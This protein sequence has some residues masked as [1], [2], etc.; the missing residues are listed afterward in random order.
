MTT[1]TANHSV[2]ELKTRTVRGGAITVAAQGAKLILQTTSTV[3]MARLLTPG[4]FGL[5]EM[6]AAF[7]GF[8]YLF[9][10]LGLSAATIQREHITHEE[11]SALFWINI[12]L[13]LLLML[14]GAAA[15]PLV[16][17]FYG[18]PELFWVM[19]AIASTFILG[20]L[21][22]QH[23]ALLQREM[24]FA[25][26]AAAEIAALAASVIG[27][28]LLSF[29]GYWALIAMTA[30]QGVTLAVCV[31]IMSGW[32][33]G[34]P[35]RGVN[36]WPML[37]FGGHLTGFNCLHYFS[38]NLDNVLIGRSVGA[39]ALGLYSRA[40]NLLMFP[41]R[42]VNQPL[43]NVAMPVLSR[44]QNEPAMYRN[45]YC[46]A[47]NFIA[48]ATGPMIALLGAAS[49]P[50]VIVL[51]GEK[52]REA[53]GIFTYLAIAA[54]FQPILWTGAWVLMS[55]GRPQ[56]LLYMAFF[57][58]PAQVASFFI[59]LP[60]GAK[61]VA[62]SYAVCINLLTPPTLY[63]ALKD[64]PVSLRDL[65]RAIWRP[66]CLSALVAGAALMTV[67]AAAGHS[68]LFVLCVVGISSALVFAGCFGAWKGLR[69]ELLSLFEL[70]KHFRRPTPAIEPP[71][72]VAATTG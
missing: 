8:I 68:S 44:L 32:I 19:I 61:G 18:R 59:G 25:Q 60:W 57:N 70:A 7:A 10:D 40:Y 71:P 53:S 3:V 43:Q 65:I 55:L 51:L 17:R 45:Y 38:R 27:G 12:F 58:D 11:V 35:R 49:G 64:S 39:V 36:V 48:Y 26:L 54:I 2:A 56:R 24:K 67:R 41:M 4:D 16:V 37:K 52:W 1:L 66:Y 5:V 14:I 63:I 15:A 34:P 29:T 23:S 28:V 31:W 62:L 9:K 46:R 72:A 13:S 47:C 33:P 50:I 42:Q 6:V 30:I 21:T 69:Q 20:G 22:A